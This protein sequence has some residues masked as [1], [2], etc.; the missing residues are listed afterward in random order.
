MTSRVLACCL[1]LLTAAVAGCSSGTPRRS[2]T[3]GAHAGI[4]PRCTA[5]TA[6]STAS[7]GL[8]A[9]HVTC[10]GPGP[11]TDLAR[12]A[13]PAVVNLWASWCYPCRQEMPLLQRAAER[14]HGRVQVVGVNTNDQAAAART[15]VA[16]VGAGYEQLS[17]PTGQL[18]LALDAPGLP[19][20]VAIDAAGA[21]VWRKAG[22]MATA[23]VSAAVRAAEQGS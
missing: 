23:D 8:P 4:A 12:L 10:L 16:K 6:A 17:D 21:I 15:F 9:V 3:T 13:G 1:A 2:P 19:Y 11:A 7:G 22:V 20:T 5:P 14:N 18:A